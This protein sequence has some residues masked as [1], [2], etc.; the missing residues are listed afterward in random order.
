M[1]KSHR[2]TEYSAHA[3]EVRESR[4]DRGDRKA[5]RKSGGELKT[6]HSSAVHVG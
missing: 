3:V 4:R 1:L 5:F 6:A 2:F